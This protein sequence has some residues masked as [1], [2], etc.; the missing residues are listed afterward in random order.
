MSKY[1]TNDIKIVYKAIQLY[2][3]LYRRQWHGL[4][5]G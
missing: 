3:L 5:G 2:Y 4:C 1:K